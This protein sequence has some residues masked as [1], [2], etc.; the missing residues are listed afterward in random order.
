[1]RRTLLVLALA[2]SVMGCP[3]ERPG[4]SRGPATTGQAPDPTPA[5][6]I[7]FTDATLRSG[8]SFIHR[9]GKS[10]AK[11]MPETLGSGVCIFDYDGDGWQDIYFVQSGS[12]SADPPAPGGDGNILYRNRGDRTFEDVTGRAGVGGTGYGMG[13]T[14]ADIDN[15]GDEDLYVT[16]F[17]KNV[18]YRNN[19]DGTFTDVTARAGVGDERWSASAAFGDYDGDGLPDLYVANYVDFTLEN[20][21]YCGEEKPGYRTY[22]HPQNYNGVPDI[23]YHNLGS[24]RFRDVTREAQ[25]YD[26]SGKGLG[27]VWGDFDGDGREDIYVANDSTPNFLY[28]N[29]GD[30]TFSDVGERAGVA[31]GET[32]L[33]QAGMGVAVADCDGNG[34]DDIFVTNLAE[35]PNALYRNE[36]ALLFSDDTYPSGLGSPSLLFLGFGTNFLDADSDGDPDLFVANGHILDNVELYSDTITYA[37]TPFF[38]ENLGGCKFRDVSAQ[39]GE[40]FRRKDVGRGSAVGDLDND[41][42]PDL[43]VSS[44]NRPPHLLLN[45]SVVPGL[46]R[47]S[48]ALAGKRGLDALGARVEVRS[49][50]KRQWAEVR[51][52]NSYLSQDEMA[53]HFGLGGSAVAEQVRIRW[54]GGAEQEFGPLVADRFYLLEEGEGSDE[55]I[56][57][58]KPRRR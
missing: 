14:F 43:V 46:H 41:G 30:G 7:R 5:T 17:G 53:L 15:D 33:P 18:L 37:Q 40:Y 50:G 4:H 39:V 32:G 23:L 52:A 55:G 3:G 38:F 16:N 49:G 45:E 54:P 34:R 13:C 20:N 28:H 1:V 42:D 12:L 44:S 27:V 9:S 51:S 57:P 22:C 47:I 8:I 25:V 48:L 21:V 56:G 31:L 19:G 11:Y 2:A 26:P 35:E 58:G 6:A 24:G 29:N 10:A 36:G